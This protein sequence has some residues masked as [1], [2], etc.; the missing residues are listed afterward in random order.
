LNEFKTKLL[1]CSIRTVGV[2]LIF[3]VL[4]LLIRYFEIDYED[5]K[6][7]LGIINSYSPELL[8]IGMLA[9]VGFAFYRSTQDETSEFDFM[10][11]F[12]AGKPEDIWKLGYFLLLLVAMWS[13]FA[14]IWR[15]KLTTEYAWA[16]FGTFVLKNAA[17]ALGKA[18]GKP[19]EETKE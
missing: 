16:V 4:G 13:I 8:L 6:A 19:R 1:M 12:M 3:W 17:D 2:V 5:V 10:H 11:F 14:L 15:D 18:F 7:V 9:G